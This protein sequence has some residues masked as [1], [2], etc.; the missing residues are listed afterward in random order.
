MKRLLIAADVDRSLLSR[1]HADGRFTI[2]DQP[3]KS[4]EELASIVGDC[5][6]LVT[7]SYNRVS[8]RVIDAAPSLELIAQGTS[9]TDNI[10][11][12][13]AHA[14]GITVIN[15][16]GENA[17]AVA[18]LVIAFMISLTRTVP[19]YD[20]EMR[21]GIWGRDD[22][23][24]RHELRHHRLG[25][26]GLGQVG[27]RVAR[28]AAA[29]G[30]R[31][32]AYDPYI[33]DDDFV[34]RGAIR[35][36]SLDA[37]LRESDIITL[38]VPFTPETKAMIG[39]KEIASMPRGAIVINAARGEVLIVDAALA[40]LSRNEIGGIAIDV[41][42]PEPPTRTWPD[43]PRLILT[44][45]IAGCTTEAKSAIGAKLYEK[46]CAHYAARSL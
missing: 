28:L 15:M 38:H 34:A 21:A 45:H 41:Y 2:I 39:A 24:S 42:D 17:N 9:G 30:M 29:F 35:L 32:T 11:I 18:E 43:D 1:A 8:K 33:S 12:A 19:A 36:T 25:I 20:R 26:I 16:P 5:E 10:D 46:I 23:A 27:M 44:P 37:L 40:A 22:C 13:A 14:R 7:R 3:V 31:V 4:E 6:I